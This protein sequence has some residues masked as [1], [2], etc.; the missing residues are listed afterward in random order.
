MVWLL[1]YEVWFQSLNSVHFPS[2]LLQELEQDSNMSP[3]HDLG[4]RSCEHKAHKNYCLV[5]IYIKAPTIA[6]FK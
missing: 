5:T 4:Q 1:Q 2:A 6:Y 3:K